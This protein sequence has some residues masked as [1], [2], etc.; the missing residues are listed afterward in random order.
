MAKMNRKRFRIRLYE[1]M[2]R[3]TQEVDGMTWLDDIG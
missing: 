1:N 3:K 2:Y